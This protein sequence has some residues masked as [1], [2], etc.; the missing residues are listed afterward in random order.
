MPLVDTINTIIS[1]P[2]Y[3][4]LFSIIKGFRNGAVYGAKIRF[5]HALV[6]TFMFRQGSLP[7]KMRAIFKA[8]FTHSRNLA[9]F[10]TIYKT[11]L[12]VL[13]RARGGKEHHADPF[14]A[15]LVGG[16]IVFGEDTNINNQIVL[17]VFSRIAVGMAKLAV[18]QE[19]IPSVPHG[20][21][22]FASLTWAIVMWLFK[23]H[24]DTLQGSLRSSMV[25]LYEDSNLFSTI[26][27]LLWVNKL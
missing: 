9:Y 1:N 16:Y 3:A 24:R 21:T 25:Y 20:Y 12:V 4:D 2:D 8:T 5:P 19:V 10:V 18:K 11:V 23:H 7:V 14:L 26:T 15:G 13:K 22:I 17:Y 27:D 6:M